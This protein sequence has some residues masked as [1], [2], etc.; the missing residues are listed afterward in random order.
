M[1]ASWIRRP[2]VASCSTH[3]TPSGYRCIGSMTDCC[4]HPFSCP[5]R[6]SRRSSIDS[7]VVTVF[8]KQEDA[9]VGYNP[10]YRGKK[11]Y[12]PLLCIEANSS[13][14]WDVELRPG[15]AGTWDG[16]VEVLDNSFANALA[17]RH[18]IVGVL[19]A[20]LGFMASI[21]LW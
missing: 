20:G 6:R 9:A 1:E 8:G 2:C 17:C 12:D 5:L 14:L 16:S 13:Y 21:L 3:L 11:S 19:R 18:P 4:N 15:N 7:T 10:R